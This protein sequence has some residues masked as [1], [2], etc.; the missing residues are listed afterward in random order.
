MISRTVGNESFRDII[1][2]YM[3]DSSIRALF[4]TSKGDKIYNCVATES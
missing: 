2:T 4:L 3:G 1:I